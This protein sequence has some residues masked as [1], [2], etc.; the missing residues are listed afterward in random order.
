MRTNAPVAKV[1]LSHGANPNAAG[2]RPYPI[3]IASQNGYLDL[4]QLLVDNGADV[5]SRD[6]SGPTVL[7]FAIALIWALARKLEF[8]IGRFTR[9]LTRDVGKPSDASGD[10]R[11]S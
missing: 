4:I 8:T 2:V 5:N 9:A 3:Q 11:T 1:L 10:C 6:L 7:H